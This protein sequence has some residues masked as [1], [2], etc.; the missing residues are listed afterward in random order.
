MPFQRAGDPQTVNIKIPVRL[1]RHPRVFRRNILNEALAALR[2]PAED[3][4][5][6][7]ALLE[8]LLFDDAL[9]AGH[10]TADVLFL[11]ILIGDSDIVHRKNLPDIS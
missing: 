5:L 1:N 7:K 4:P 6:F 3:Q 9:L 8:P 11:N 10:R 2:A